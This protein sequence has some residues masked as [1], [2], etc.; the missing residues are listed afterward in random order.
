MNELRAPHAS[1]LLEAELG[2]VEPESCARNQ[3]D[4]GLNDG[5]V[6]FLDLHESFELAPPP[7]QLLMLLLP[8][9]CGNQERLGRLIGLG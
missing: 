6:T 7:A 8:H 2:S 4:L 5:D 1:G 3:V 9:W